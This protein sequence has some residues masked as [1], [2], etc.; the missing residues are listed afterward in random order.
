MV[1]FKSGAMEGLARFTLDVLALEGS[2][3]FALG[4]LALVVFVDV[5]V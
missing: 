4:I 2:A 1:T 3:R 5:V